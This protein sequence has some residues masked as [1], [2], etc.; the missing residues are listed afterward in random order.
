VLV[1]PTML[2]VAP[3]FASYDPEAMLRQPTF[4]SIWNLTGLPAL[5]VGCGYSPEG[6]PIGFQII[7]KPFDEPTVL[8]VGDAYQRLTDWHARRP[9]VSASVPAAETS[10]SSEPVRTNGV[11]TAEDKGALDAILE[12][13]GLS[14][15]GDEYDKLLRA[16]P[17]LQE[18][19]A[20]LR[21]PEVRYA[22]P[23]VIYPAR[24]A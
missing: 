9:Q 6:L 17:Y 24:S 4:M 21:R 11:P 18:Q 10:S 7:G 23:A 5:S 3:L 20:E 14:I 8:K 15:V 12:R 13:A 22:E 2:N 1:T 16:Y 19:L